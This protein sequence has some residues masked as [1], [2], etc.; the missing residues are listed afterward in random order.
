MIGY[1]T[2]RPATRVYLRVGLALEQRAL[3]RT[4]PEPE[5]GAVPPPL[6][7]LLTFLESL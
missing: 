4:M 2:P 6:T 3:A 5:A 1:E 7:P